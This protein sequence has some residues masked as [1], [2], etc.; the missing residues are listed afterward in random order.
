MKRM[1]LLGVAIWLLTISTPGFAVKVAVVRS[2]GSVPVFDELNDNWQL[3]GNIPLNIDTSLSEVSMFTYDQ[4]VAVAADVLWLSDPAGGME[5]YSAQEVAAVERYT[6][7][8]HSILGTFKVF[9]HRDKDNRALAP[10]FGL[11][12]EMEYHSADDGADHA[13]T[14]FNDLPDH[15]LF[16]RLG[17]SYVG[18]GHPYAQVP[19]D[20]FTWD[21]GDFGSAQLV[22][23]TDDKRGVITWYETPTYNAIFVS[24]MP[25]YRG[26]TADTQF[27][28]NALTIPEPT[29]LLLVGLGALGLLLRRTKKH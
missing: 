3:Y 21:E 29:T 1:A 22:A 11:L 5:Q 20:D 4:L 6:S 16:R 13:S 19:E 12:E 10:I 9:Q 24:L 23:R 15:R 14:T 28:Y 18:D 27:L 8:G 7:E 2:W 17:D 25:E 26:N